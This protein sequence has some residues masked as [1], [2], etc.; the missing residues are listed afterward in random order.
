V[1]SI[2]S[3]LLP[4]T[5]GLPGPGPRADARG[6]DSGQG[7]WR[8]FLLRARNRRRLIPPAGSRGISLPGR[9][10]EGG[11][12]AGKS[13]TDMFSPTRRKDAGG[14]PGGAR[15]RKTSEACSAR[16]GVLPGFCFLISSENRFSFLHSQENRPRPT[17]DPPLFLEGKTKFFSGASVGSRPAYLLSRR[18]WHGRAARLTPR[19]GSAGRGG[20]P[21]ASI[22]LGPPEGP[23]TSKAAGARR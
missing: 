13:I 15:S 2:P 23:A 19:R 22:L 1:C 12:V 9:M 20:G 7:P 14:G 18:G 3:A 17:V 11:G 5:P 6:A 4:P 21:P 16:G 8:A 10:T